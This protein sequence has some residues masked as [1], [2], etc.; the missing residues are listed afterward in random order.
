MASPKLETGQAQQQHNTNSPYVQQALP[1]FVDIIGPNATFGLVW[2]GVTANPTPTWASLCVCSF[3]SEVQFG[4]PAT[5]SKRVL[6]Q[7]GA[8]VNRLAISLESATTS[9][10]VS[11]IVR[12][13]RSNLS[14]KGLGTDDASVLRNI[15]QKKHRAILKQ[16]DFGR[17]KEINTDLEDEV[18]LLRAA[19]LA[20]SKEKSAE[21]LFV[22]PSPDTDSDSDDDSVF[23]EKMLRSQEE[24]DRLQRRLRRLSAER[25]RLSREDPDL[26]ILKGKG[27]K[28]PMSYSTT[29]VQPPGAK[30]L[31]TTEFMESVRMRNEQLPTTQE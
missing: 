12:H 24:Y 13:I 2:N 10:E 17:K 6:F 31:S 26:Q 1:F 22:A 25:D 20:I 18:K 8:T 15:H 5:L 16:F 4:A 21:K 7:N 27:Q 19:V 11:R 30:L 14:L 3:P 29:P 23:L 9:K 28:R